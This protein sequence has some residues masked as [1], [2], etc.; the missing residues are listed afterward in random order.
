MDIIGGLDAISQAISANSYQNELSFQ[1]AL[2]GLISSANDGHFAFIPDIFKVFRF[3]IP[4]SAA[5]VCVSAD[6]KT[7]PQLFT[8]GKNMRVGTELIISG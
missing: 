1:L 7:L 3:R 2:T 5:L 6:G 4:Q 8:F